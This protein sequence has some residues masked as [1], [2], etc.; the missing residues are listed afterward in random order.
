M[1]ADVLI[2]CLTDSDAYRFG[3]NLNKIFDYFASGRPVI[4]SGN[5]PNDPVAES[6]AGF[7]I[8]PEDP[9]AMIQSLEKLLKAGPEQR[10][11]MGKRGRQY[12]EDH[13][14]MHK[15]AERME[16]LLSQAITEKRRGGVH[17][18]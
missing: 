12:V 15:L 2:A 18:S 16:R 9:E 6:G 14:N 13:F 17:A 3:L 4:F 10:A 1:E 11:E 8:P 5:A 7:S